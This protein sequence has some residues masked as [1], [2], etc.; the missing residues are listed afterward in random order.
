M[1][2]LSAEFVQTKNKQKEF[3]KGIKQQQN[4]KKCVI[5]LFVLGEFSYQGGEKTHLQV[6]GYLRRLNVIKM[7]PVLYYPK[8]LTETEDVSV[9]K[10]SF[11]AA[12]RYYYLQDPCRRENAEK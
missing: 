11:L 10:I 8:L 7:S 1:E 6:V 5:F 2:V 4:D 9:R 12:R 3:E